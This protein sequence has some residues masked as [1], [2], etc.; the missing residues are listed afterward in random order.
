MIGAASSKFHTQTRRR[1]HPS[2]AV[3]HSQELFGDPDTQIR[4]NLRGVDCVPVGY[5]RSVLYA[6]SSSRRVPRRSRL[7]EACYHY[8]TKGM[9][10]GLF[11]CQDKSPAG[12]KEADD[13][14]S[15]SR[16][17]KNYTFLGT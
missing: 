13:W 14:A 9:P 17:S 2:L 15:F 11:V 8:A 10:E 3:L 5:V 4:W 1:R 16:S 6:P 7:L 12:T